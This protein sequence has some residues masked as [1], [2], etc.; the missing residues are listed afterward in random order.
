MKKSLPDSVVLTVLFLNFA[1]SQPYDVV[2]KRKQLAVYV[3]GGLCL[4][5]KLDFMLLRVFHLTAW[6]DSLLVFCAPI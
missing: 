1:H 6:S 4:I 2:V 3:N 5:V